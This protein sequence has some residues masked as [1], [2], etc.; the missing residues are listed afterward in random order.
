MKY[1]LLIISFLI[2]SC[3]HK[4]HEINLHK[5]TNLDAYF[6]T[7]YEIRFSDRIDT[8]EGYL[9]EIDY[10]HDTTIVI[11]SDREDCYEESDNLKAIYKGSSVVIRKLN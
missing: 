10:L 1:L 7:V 3:A 8:V 2:L 6:P 5:Y 4:S 9:R 11:C